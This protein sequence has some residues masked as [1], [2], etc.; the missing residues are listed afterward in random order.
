VA[1][2]RETLSNVARHAGASRTDVTLRVHD[3][4][5][6]TVSDDGTGIADGTPLSGLANLACRATELGGTFEVGPASDGA[7]RPGT[8]VCWRVPL[9]PGV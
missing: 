1:V 2:L 4:V 6:I 8:V 5:V 3:D 7:A 9:A